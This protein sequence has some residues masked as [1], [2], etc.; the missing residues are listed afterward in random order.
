MIQSTNEQYD[1]T[2]VSLSFGDLF[3]LLLGKELSDSRFN[4]GGVYIH[5]NAYGILRRMVDIPRRLRYNAV[6]ALKG[7]RLGRKN[8]T[9]V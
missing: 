9:Q 4:S 2:T 1:F 3:K 5:L 6:A 7:L 8:N